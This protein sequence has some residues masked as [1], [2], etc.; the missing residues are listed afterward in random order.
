MF[1]DKGARR[2]A[3]VAMHQAFD[4]LTVGFQVHGSDGK[5]SDVT[6]ASNSAHAG[7]GGELLWGLHAAVH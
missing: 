4:F 1:C 3:G 7:G 5:L 2:A 6:M